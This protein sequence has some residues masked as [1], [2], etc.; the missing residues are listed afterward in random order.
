MSEF[1]WTVTEADDGEKIFQ[2]NREQEGFV[3]TEKRPPPLKG[4]LENTKSKNFNEPD[5]KYFTCK[6]WSQLKRGQVLK[7][8][9]LKKDQSKNS[10]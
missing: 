1:S 8:T 7:Y 3:M 4:F 9:D 10:C 5:D 2:D 6:E